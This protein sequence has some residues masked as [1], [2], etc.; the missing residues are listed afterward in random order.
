MRNRSET[1]PPRASPAAQARG[2][3]AFLILNAKTTRNHNAPGLKNRGL[4]TVLMNLHNQPLCDVTLTRPS[5]TRLRQEATNR[6]VSRWESGLLAAVFD[7]AIYVRQRTLSSIV[8]QLQ[9]R[10]G[11]CVHFGGGA[12]IEVE[13]VRTES[14]RTKGAYILGSDV[15]TCGFGV[16]ANL[17]QLGQTQRQ[18]GRSLQKAIYVPQFDL[19]LS[20]GRVAR[21][22][23]DSNLDVDDRA[24]PP[25]AYGA[26]PLSTGA[27]TS[28]SA[29]LE[30]RSHSQALPGLTF[31]RTPIR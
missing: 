28:A 19:R 13:N 15:P 8:L 7:I 11:K 20:P 9:P 4:R 3:S 22:S 16:I 10:Y 18:G 30:S 14:L 12:Y 24:T 1:Q 29:R 26:T 6:S 2:H 21:G 17:L 25:P 27:K 31:A 5:A 23:V